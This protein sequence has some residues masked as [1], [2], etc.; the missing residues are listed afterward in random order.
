[1]AG[2]TCRN[3][4]CQAVGTTYTNTTSSSRILVATTQNAGAVWSQEVLDLEGSMYG[5]TCQGSTCISVGNFIASEVNVPGII[6]STNQGPWLSRTT[7]FPDTA[8]YGALSSVSCSDSACIAV[9]SYADV[10]VA[11]QTAIYVSTNLGSTWTQQP[12]LNFTGYSEAAFTGISCSSGYCVAVGYAI[13]PPNSN[14]PSAPVLAVSNAEGT[15]WSQQIVPTPS[16]YTSCT[17]AGVT[18]SG[19]TCTAVGGCSSETAASPFVVVST[20]N[21]VT[22]SEQLIAQPA[23]S[24]AQLFSVG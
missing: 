18:C 15:S 14:N 6:T 5:I 13:N 12:Q 17:L 1:M 8:V 24:Y 23:E 4:L 21:G 22:W 7:P 10:S 2:I 19:T 20:D 9:G 16:P 11:I 3:A